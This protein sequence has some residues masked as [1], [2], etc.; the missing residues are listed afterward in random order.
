MAAL[1]KVLPLVD[2][3]QWHSAQAVPS[4][5]KLQ[6]RTILGKV[7]DQSA[8]THGPI[9]RIGDS[10][11]MGARFLSRSITVIYDDK[12][13]PCGV[14]AAQFILLSLISRKPI[15]RAD[16]AR[17][18]HLERSTLTRNLKTILAKGWVEEVRDNA[19]GRSRPIA[20]TA[21]GRELLL[22]AEPEWLA[23]EVAAMALL[24][25]DG[26]ITIISVADRF[27]HSTDTVVSSEEH[28][29]D[30]RR[31]DDALINPAD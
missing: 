19:N 4:Y 12:L 15:T 27:A 28:D 25:T 8:L 1:R 17:L 3:P 13:R 23:A 14:T 5:N 22:K 18:Q 20:L 7:S 2:L 16:V 24:G 30:P 11:L 26:M 21:A 9:A 6:G 31:K 29:E 10:V